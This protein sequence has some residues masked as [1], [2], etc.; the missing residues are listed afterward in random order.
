VNISQFKKYG[1]GIYVF[2]LYLIE[3]L[4]TFAVLFIFAFHYM[5]CIFY[6]YYVEYEEY[7]EIY[8]FFFNYNILSLVS[9]VQLIKFRKYDIDFFGKRHFLK[10]YKDFDVIYKEYLYSGTIVFIIVFLINFGFM[11]YL[12]KIYKLYRIENPEIKNY[13]LILSG[14]NVPYI[15]KDEIENDENASID[16]QKDVIKNEILKE[17]NIKNADINFTFKLSKYYE[18]MQK[19]TI[20]R[21]NK[22]TT[23]Y[24]VTRNKCCCYGCCCFCGKCFC[25]C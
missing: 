5:Y 20:L 15:K 14:K 7:E 10:N 8:S 16:N 9:G 2:F 17:L 21:N 25:C 1:F 4:V 18:K 22:Y 12:Q 13:S 19:Y 3:L 23:Q 6:K 11:L 24:K